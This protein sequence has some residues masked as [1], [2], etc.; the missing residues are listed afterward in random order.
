M[1]ACG[2]W[3]DAACR[4]LQALDMLRPAD[5]R[6]LPYPGFCTDTQPRC[7][8]PITKSLRRKPVCGKKSLAERRFL[9][10]DELKR[11]GGDIRVLD[12]CA[13]VNRGGRRLKGCEVNGSGTFEPR[14]PTPFKYLGGTGTAQLRGLSHLY[15]GYEHPRVKLRSL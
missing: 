6:T 1:E 3:R 4:A 5:V 11:I 14:L 2:R 13:L 10:S 9:A 7:M 15:R 8:A 12:N